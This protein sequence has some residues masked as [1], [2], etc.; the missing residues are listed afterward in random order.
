[1]CFIYWQ[2][3]NDCFVLCARRNECL[4]SLL[5][6]LFVIFGDT[7]TSLCILYICVFVSFVY[8]LF[9]YLCVFVLLWASVLLCLVAICGQA[10]PSSLELGGSLR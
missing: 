10:G 7:G 2:D 4:A 6:C 3:N 8:L 5:L 1:M 9:V